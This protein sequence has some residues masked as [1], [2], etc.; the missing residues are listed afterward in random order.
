M[1]P[2]RL[3][4]NQTQ[5]TLSKFAKAHG[6]GAASLFPREILIIIT[7]TIQCRTSD[8]PTILPAMNEGHELVKNTLKLR[9]RYNST[10][11]VNNTVKTKHR[12]IETTP[13]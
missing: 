9:N 2:S 1:V 10:P 12:L 7:V 3:L 4:V 13:N 5:R 6:I 11:H 8:D